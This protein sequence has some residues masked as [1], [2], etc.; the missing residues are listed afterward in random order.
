MKSHKRWL[1]IA[2]V[3]FALIYAIAPRTD[4]PPKTRP[5][6]DF[7]NA[8]RS[9]DYARMEQYRT[10]P[11]LG[12]GADTE[13]DGAVVDLEDVPKVDPMVLALPPT[14]DT[15]IVFDAKTILASPAGKLL[16]E[17]V[18][19][20]ETPSLEREGFTYDSIERVGLAMSE[21]DDGGMRGLTVMTG[22]IADHA[23]ALT[24]GHLPSPYGEHGQLFENEAAG[25]VLATW[26][27]EMTMFGDSRAELEQAIDRLEGR[28]RI[29]RPAIAEEQSYGDVYGRISP[30][31]VQ[32]MLHDAIPDLS[33]DAQLGLQL[34]FHVDANKDVL[35]VLDANGGGDN[36]M[37][38]GRTLGAA[39]GARRV[40]A[41]IE[42]DQQ[43]AE[44]LDYFK[45]DT[46]YGWFSLNAALPLAF[47][48]DALADC[49]KRA[50][51]RRAAK[52]QRGQAQRADGGVP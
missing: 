23:H 26:K 14:P 25:M 9:I 28:R 41:S 44:L 19:G 30:K 49:T 1:V 40:Q 16:M 8:M 13:V 35:I 37:D 50:R 4:P 43:L 11:V 2:L 17:C 46:S 36:T 32:E 5:E 29:E 27:G 31:M 51:E 39:I 15:A 42:D 18:S 33:I 6:L 47:V 21:A 24:R 34:D 45:V 38:L 10:L 52:E 12:H 48:E 20:G 22:P 3:L 7:P